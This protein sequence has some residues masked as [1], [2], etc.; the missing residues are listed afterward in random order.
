MKASSGHSNKKLHN[1]LIYHFR[2][3]FFARYAPLYK[4]KLYDL[5]CGEASFKPFLL[6]YCDEY[7]GVD[8]QGSFHATQA[9]IAADLNQP[10]P[11]E[12]NQADTLISISVLEHLS[13]PQTMLNEAYRILKPGGAFILQC[14]WQWMVHEAPYDFFRYSPY[15]LDY[16]FKKAGFSNIRI[17]PECGFW[18]MWFLK[19]CYF[20]RRFVRGPKP[21]QLLLII[22]LTPFWTI[23]QL[24]GLAMNRMDNNP[25]LEACGYYV[26]AKKGE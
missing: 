1:W 3:R 10:L 14:P 25:M 13:E 17:E 15:G 20:L 5:G 26:V 9:D 22:L 16:M 6:Q 21:L 12:N 8:W 4:G 11:I 19:I 24:L 18:A 23:F 7:I 2:N